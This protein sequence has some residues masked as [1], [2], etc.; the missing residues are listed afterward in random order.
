MRIAIL[1]EGAGEP[2]GFIRVNVKIKKFMFV[3]V[4]LLNFLSNFNNFRWKGRLDSGK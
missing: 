4:S 1:G 3:P 2:Y